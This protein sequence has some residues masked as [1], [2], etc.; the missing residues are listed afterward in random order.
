MVAQ[1]TWVW[2]SETFWD[3]ANP[4]TSLECPGAGVPE[5]VAQRA[6]GAGSWSAAGAPVSEMAEWQGEF[7]H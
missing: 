5:P 7:W 6:F 1:G 3:V 4:C 2:V